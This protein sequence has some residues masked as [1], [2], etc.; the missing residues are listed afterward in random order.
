MASYQTFSEF[1]RDFYKCYPPKDAEN[2]MAMMYEELCD[3]LVPRG[4]D[5]KYIS[6]GKEDFSEMAGCCIRFYLA[7]EDVGDIAF[8]ELTHWMWEWGDNSV[9]KGAPASYTQVEGDGFKEVRKTVT[10]VLLKQ[11]K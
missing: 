4:Y 1:W 6:V 9:L 11:L 2:I 8:N 10:D 3:I 7:G 5:L